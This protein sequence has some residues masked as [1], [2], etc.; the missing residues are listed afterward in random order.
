MLRNGKWSFASG[1]RLLAVILLLA[2]VFF[3]VTLVACNLWARSHYRAAE[4][5]LH[6]D[7]M[8]EARAHISQCLRVWQR[9]AA[10]QL[11]AARIERIRS[12]FPEAE[13][14]LRECIRLQHGPS[15]A[16]QLEAVLLRVQNGE[17]KELEAGLW[18]CVETDHPETT[19]ILETLARIHLADSRLGAAQIY[20]DRWLEREPQTARAWYWRGKLYERLFQT[21]KALGDYQKT[22]ELK[23]ECWECRLR[24]AHLLL[25][26]HD[27]SE[28]FPHLQ[29]LERSHAEEPEVAVALARYRHLNGDDAEAIR[30][31]DQTLAT[32]PHFYDALVLRG[33]LA[34]LQHRPEEGESWLRQALAQ[35][36]NDSRT[37]YIFYQCLQQQGKESEAAKVLARQ[38]AAEKDTER[39]TQLLTYEI[40][41]THGNPDVLAEVGV[42][43][44]R[45]GEDKLGV[46]WL[47][48]ALNE[49]PNHQ[50]SHEALLRHFESQGDT[51]KAEQHRAKLI[52]RKQ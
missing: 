49:N 21:K 41:Q 52:V 26:G 2:I 43:W 46:E 18:K 39:L 33:Q 8:A 5:A 27:A 40:K 42:L 45:L 34:C 32:N 12:H 3:P 48:R 29:E 36:P 11:L 24:L 20:L 9:D 17:W 25:D 23:P 1:I 15:E 16:T 13:Q 31:L 47:Y 4:K 19:Q 37:L 28:A 14:H 10:A 38:K 7:R 6:D 44:L 22:L 50:P 35:Q 30:L 51:E